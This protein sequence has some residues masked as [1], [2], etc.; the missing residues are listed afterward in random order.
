[1]KE[2]HIG[3]SET[4]NST[5]SDIRRK[6]KYGNLYLK[7]YSSFSNQIYAKVKSIYQKITRRD[8]ES[9]IN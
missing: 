3:I 6:R 9:N 8:F 7:I 4:Q 1:M 2:I 5:I